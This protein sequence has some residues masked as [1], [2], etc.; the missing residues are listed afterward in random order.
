MHGDVA[1]NVWKVGRGLM[2]L[3]CWLRGYL[4]P[5]HS[6]SRGRKVAITTQLGG[7]PDNEQCLSGAPPN[8]IQYLIHVVVLCCR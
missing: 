1:L 6:N 8:S 3:M 4:Y 7:A 2:S 5:N